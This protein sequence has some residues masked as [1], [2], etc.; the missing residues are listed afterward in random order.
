MRTITV[1]DRR[2]VV[3][4]MLSILDKIDPEGEH[5][6]T[7]DP[8]KALKV[9]KEK[10][11]TAAFVDVEMPKI[12]G[13]VLAKMMQ[14]INAEIAEKYV[15]PKTKGI[16]LSTPNNP[17]GACMHREDLEAMVKL[18]EKYDLLLYSDEIY[19]WYSY[20]VP[21]ISV[22][23]I[24]GAAERTVVINSMSKNYVCTG[25]RLAWVIAPV[26]LIG[27]MVKEGMNM[28]FTAPSIS[29]RMA[30]YAL[31]EGKALMAP[32]MAEFK[33]RMFR[34]AERINQ[35]PHLKVQSPPPGT[36]YLFVNVKEIGLTDE[37]FVLKVLEKAH[38]AL[39]PGS[40]FGEHGA[41][42][43]RICCTVGL[44][45]LMEAMDR[46]ETLGL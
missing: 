17:T 29:Q 38:V 22:L 33:E 15:T 16:F 5:I 27:A 20:E 41:G 8:E 21:F 6:G 32:I 34:T 36:F 45:K 31:N 10:D 19:T 14:E 40:N 37:E 1:D 2:S 28:V 25:A 23:S 43:V 30:K 44:P 13:I 4:M 46:I 24:P 35:I 7:T 26:P 42:Y 11:V 12:N 9:L 39:V 3:N 18:A